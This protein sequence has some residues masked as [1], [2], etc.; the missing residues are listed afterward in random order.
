MIPDSDDKIYVIDG[1]TCGLNFNV[2]HTKEVYDQ[3][4]EWVEWNGVKCS[5]D[6]YWYYQARVD[7]DL[8]AANKPN[9]DDTELN[10][11][12]TGQITPL[13]SSATYQIR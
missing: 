8:D 5:D 10:D 3:F 4:R 11:V 13:P 6:Y 1:P 9:N 12:S 2:N 7:D